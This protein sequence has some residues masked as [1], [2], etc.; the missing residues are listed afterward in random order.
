MANKIPGLE[1]LF[2]AHVLFTSKNLQTAEI[3]LLPN[4]ESSCASA[5]ESSGNTKAAADSCP[6]RRGG[7]LLQRPREDGTLVIDGRCFS[8]CN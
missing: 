4:S 8:R 6:L 5:G 7:P 2:F 1:E 3:S